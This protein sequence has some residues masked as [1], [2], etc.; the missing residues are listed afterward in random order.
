MPKHGPIIIIEDDMDDRF[1]LE[2]ALK[3][4]NVMNELIFFDNG[5]DAYE[6]LLNTTKDPFI[7]LCDVNLPRQ[8]GI[9]FKKELDNNHRLRSMGIPFI[10]YTTYVSQYAVNEAYKNTTVQG[11]FQKNNTHKE[12]R[13][14]V[15][16]IIDYW[17]I[18]RQPQRID[19]PA[20]DI[21]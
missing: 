18:C 3:E 15:K 21:K 19:K 13:D 11:F 9:E 8:N 7:I 1:T 2:I 4:A 14:V 10:F 6:F 12:L 20:T 17:R 5:P 16:I